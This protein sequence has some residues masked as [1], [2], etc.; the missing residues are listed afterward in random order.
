MRQLISGTECNGINRW[1][2][3][4]Q[5]ILTI[6]PN[7]SKQQFYLLGNDLPW[8][9]S[10]LSG[11]IILRGNKDEIDLGG[12]PVGVYLLKVGSRVGKLIRE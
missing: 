6:Y 7:P 3:T 1:E 4:F 5:D 8:E 11:K 10:E 2:D 12:F 9:V